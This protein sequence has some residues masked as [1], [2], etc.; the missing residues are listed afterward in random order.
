M[1]YEMQRR[2]GSVSS[3]TRYCPHQLLIAVIGHGRYLAVSPSNT[4][5][6][7]PVALNTVPSALALRLYP[8]SFALQGGTA[9]Q[10]SSIPL[11]SRPPFERCSE[12]PSDT[13][14]FHGLHRLSFLLAV[15]L[16]RELLETGAHPAKPCR[17]LLDTPRGTSILKLDFPMLLYL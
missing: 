7:E 5:D 6:R 9:S 10:R 4:G 16:P 8:G 12:R 1:P 17:E 15:F 3:R 11:S 13:G 2:P 14:P